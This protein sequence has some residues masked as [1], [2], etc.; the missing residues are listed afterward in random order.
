MNITMNQQP[1]FCS[2]SGG[3]DSSLAF[4]Q[5]K[6]SGGTPSYLLTM[7]I[8]TGERSRS[9]GILKAVLEEQAH[10]MGI[11]IRFCATS[12]DSYTEN[13]VQ[14][15]NHIQRLNIRQGV[16]G[17]IDIE[18]HRKWV[19]NAC[20]AG[21]M[22]AWLP[23]WQTERSLLVEELLRLTFKAEIV[24]VK[25]GV[26]PPSYLGKTL[27]SEIIQEFELLGIDACGENGEYHTLVTDGP[28]FNRP[29]SIVHGQQVL[30]DG[31]WFSDVSLKP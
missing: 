27:T 5:A 23:L 31:Y 28:I 16:F 22:S 29:L 3:K 14:E 1:F 4:Y 17:D 8:E 6:K 20:K 30:R 9:H 25:E 12:W 26:L 21:N 15:L 18:S 19:E 11:P 24:S 10:C 13:F 2:W 7:M